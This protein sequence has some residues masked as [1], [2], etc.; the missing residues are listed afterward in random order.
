MIIS[1]TVLEFENWKLEN[2]KK[3]RVSAFPKVA[4]SG[5]IGKK[6]PVPGGIYNV[7]YLSMQK[8]N[9]GTDS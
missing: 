8:V 5:N 6:S 1:S 7:R 3:I 4:K 9:C 2:G